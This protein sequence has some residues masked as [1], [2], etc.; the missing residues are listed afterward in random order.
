MDLN[1]KPLMFR[2]G[3]PSEDEAR[4]EGQ[5]AYAEEKTKELKEQKSSDK[6]LRFGVVV[7]VIAGLIVGIAT[8][9]WNFFWIIGC[10]LAGGIAGVLLG[11]LIGALMARG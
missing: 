3:D 7:G 11:S 9:N 2:W 1:R 10:I 8:G 5:I 4:A 6:Y